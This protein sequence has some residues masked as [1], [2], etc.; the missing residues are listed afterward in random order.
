VQVAV[1]AGPAFAGWIILSFGVTWAFIV[2]ALGYVFLT[3]AFSL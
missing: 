1:F 2:N 3:H